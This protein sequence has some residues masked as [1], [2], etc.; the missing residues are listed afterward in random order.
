MV[1]G[2]DDAVDHFDDELVGVLLGGGG[3]DVGRR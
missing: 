3:G 1:F 2:D